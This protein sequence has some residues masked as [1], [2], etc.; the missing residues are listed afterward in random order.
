MDRINGGGESLRSLSVV[1]RHNLASATWSQVLLDGVTPES[2]AGT[3][4]AGRVLPW[5][6]V[7]LDA[8]RG[9][10]SVLDLGSG[11]GE[12]AAALA[13]EGK[14]VTLVDWSADNLRFSRDVFS[15][16]G[17]SGEF[18]HADLTQ[19]LPFPSASY[20]LVFSCGVLEFFSD[21][22]IAQVIQESWRIST[23]RVI[24]L[25]PNALSAAYRIGKWYMARTGRW[26]WDGEVPF[27]TLKPFF[28]PLR[29]ARVTEYSI[30]PRHALKFLDMPLG[31][32]VRMLLMRALQTSDDTGPA[33][34]RQ[35]YLLFT[36]ADHH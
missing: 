2:V 19:P 10:R 29:S 5:T 18:C 14:Q 30:A 20:D 4:A 7:L 24:I 26:P 1:R 28:D 13:R 33:F 23:R 17:L 35:G 25:V 36:Q 6:K 11:R 15:R 27:R 16:L 3:V 12:L 8:S 21:E 32:Q 31:R 9:A 22:Q 34:L